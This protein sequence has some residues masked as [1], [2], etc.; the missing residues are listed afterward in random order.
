[1]QVLFMIQL[2]IVLLNLMK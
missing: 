2:I 1:M